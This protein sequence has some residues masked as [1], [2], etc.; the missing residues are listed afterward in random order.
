MAFLEDKTVSVV[1]QFQQ[2]HHL[3]TT[4]VVTPAL[5]GA[6]EGESGQPNVSV[7]KF[8]TGSY[9]RKGNSGAVVV[10]LQAALNAA[11]ADPSIKEDGVFSSDTVAALKAFQKK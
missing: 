9:L 8:T 10:E 6:I 5:L 3:E 11:G 4:G 7:K 1:K 2:D